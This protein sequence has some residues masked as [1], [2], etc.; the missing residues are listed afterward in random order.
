MAD[1]PGNFRFVFRVILQVKTIIVIVFV[2]FNQVFNHHW[3]ARHP[4]AV[5]QRGKKTFMKLLSAVALGKQLN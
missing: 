4:H 2:I 1:W 3:S 5:R